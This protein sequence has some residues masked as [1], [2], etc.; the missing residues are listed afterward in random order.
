MTPISPTGSPSVIC[1]GRPDVWSPGG[2]DCRMLHP[3][4]RYSGSSIG[5]QLS[6]VISGRAGAVD[7]YRAARRHRISYV[8]ALYILFCAIVSIVATALMPDYTNEDIAEE[9]DKP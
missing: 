2:V 8:I 4:A 3:E 7:R 5:Y 1:T 9:H 6:S